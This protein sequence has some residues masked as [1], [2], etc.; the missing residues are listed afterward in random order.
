MLIAVM[1]DTHGNC[2]AIDKAVETAKDADVIIHLGDIIN[3][4]DKIRQGFKKTVICV[5]GNC[6]YNSFEES[7][8]LIELEGVKLLLCHGDRYRVDIGLISL[9]YR[10]KEVGARIVLFGHTHRS[11]IIEEDDIMF[12]N[13]GSAALPRDFKKSIGFI[14]ISDGL[15]E[16][17]IKPL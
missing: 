11:L 4:V 9:K 13:P 7:E 14:S 8:K 5:P 15:V 2:C 16:G 6:D 10:A 17:Y 1:S 12:M 3:D